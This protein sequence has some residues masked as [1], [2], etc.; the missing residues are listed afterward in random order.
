VCSSP[1]SRSSAPPA[2]SLHLA[3][4]VLFR[5][6]PTPD[7]DQIIG[8]HAPSRPPLRAFLTSIQTS[9]PPVP[10]RH[11][12]QRSVLCGVLLAA[13]APRTHHSGIATSRFTT[14]AE[15]AA[16]VRRIFERVGQERCSL[17]EVRRR[18]Q[19]SM[20]LPRL[21]NTSGLGR[22]YVTCANCLFIGTRQLS[23][24]G[25]CGEKPGT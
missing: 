16:I 3:L 10:P 20:K 9:V 1:L 2:L 25:R 24:I 22:P 4:S 8:D 15:Q 11:Y 5:R 7:M 17:G 19:S 6:D 21:E 12:V 13:R 18:L 23:E 14:E